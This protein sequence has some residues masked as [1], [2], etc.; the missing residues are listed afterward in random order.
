MTILNQ[1][2]L[3][4]IFP[5]DEEMNAIIDDAYDADIA[6]SIIKT[7]HARGLTQEDFAKILGVSQSYVSQLESASVLPSHKK[8]K[9][10]ARTLKAKLIAPQIELSKS[11]NN[12]FLQFIAY[13]SSPK[14]ASRT[15]KNFGLPTNAEY[16]NTMQYA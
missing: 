14:S 15:T 4:Q 3:E 8:L 10:I 16:Q 5:T 11:E 7:R 2:P 9:F 13:E 6:V 1:Y 12:V